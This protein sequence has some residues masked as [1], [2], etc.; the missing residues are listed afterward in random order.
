M[1]RSCRW[2]LCSGRPALRCAQLLVFPSELV[3]VGVPLTAVESDGRLLS[4]RDAFADGE[5]LG[6]DLLRRV[7]LS[8]RGADP[9][10][11]EV[12]GAD[13]RICEE[14]RGADAAAGDGFREPD[15]IY[16][17]AEVIDKPLAPHAERLPRLHQGGAAG[18]VRAV[19]A[20]E[21]KGRPGSRAPRPP[22]H[23]WRAGM[24]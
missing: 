2:L 11:A 5:D 16:R 1:R 10:G 13:R 12:C 15:L 20:L 3:D 21:Q 8:L 19:E 7:E 4:G 22:V 17:R 9:L 14:A 24:C 18:A 23:R 6:R